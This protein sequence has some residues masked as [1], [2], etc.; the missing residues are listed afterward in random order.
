MKLSSSTRLHMYP[1]CLCILRNI[2]DPTWLS[3]A[4]KE[5]QSINQS[6]FKDCYREYNSYL[7]ATLHESFIPSFSPPSS[8]T[9]W[10]LK[11]FS[12]FSLSSPHMRALISSLLWF[13]LLPFLSLPRKSQAFS[14]QR[15]SPGFLGSDLWYSPPLCSMLHHHHPPLNPDCGMRPRSGSGGRGRGTERYPASWISVG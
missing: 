10:S 6:S 7:T 11:A 1:D 13:F 8:P 12:H 4:V 5:T 15:P 9:H 14:N 2:P 3:F